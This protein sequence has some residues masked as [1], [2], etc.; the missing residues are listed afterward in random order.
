M[1][2]AR[3]CYVCRI[4]VSFL[5]TASTKIL[6]FFLILLLPLTGPFKE[7]ELVFKPWI[8]HEYSQVRAKSQ[9]SYLN[10]RASPEVSLE[11]GFRNE[12]RGA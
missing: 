1:A 5:V 11:I 4:L 6:P 2:R 3:G 12:Q 10:V 7:A 9:M 8:V